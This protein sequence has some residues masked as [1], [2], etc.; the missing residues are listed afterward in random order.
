MKLV[1]KKLAGQ[2]VILP[3]V[4]K[5]GKGG[6]VT[7]G[8]DGTF[9]V[10]EK[11]GKQILDAEVADISRVGEKSKAQ[12]GSENK[13]SAMQEQIDNAV[14]NITSM[15]SYADLHKLCEDAKLDKEVWGKMKVPEL[16][17]YLIGQIDPST[18]E[19]AP[20]E[21]SDAAEGKD[22]NPVEGS[23]AAEG[24]DEAQSDEDKGQGSEDNDPKEEE[25]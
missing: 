15:K 8:K 6:E 12:Q 11:V 5:D 7:Y 14:A 19:A 4:G 22:E 23:D 13:K 17:A 2:T 9:E 20:V 10:S 16:K 21:G 18:K 25:K 24:K 1:N 3:F